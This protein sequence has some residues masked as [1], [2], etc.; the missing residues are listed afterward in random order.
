[1]FLDFAANI[2]RKNDLRGISGKFAVL[3]AQPWDCQERGLNWPVD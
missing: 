2:L 1:M 3:K